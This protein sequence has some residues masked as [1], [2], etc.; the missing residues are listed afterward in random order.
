MAKPNKSTKSK[1]NKEKQEKYDADNEIVIGVTTKRVEEKK[2][3]HTHNKRKKSNTKIIK[4]S[5]NKNTK[6]DYSKE[7]IIK[8][9]NKKRFLLG[10]FVSFL[11][12]TGGIIFLVTT[13]KCYITDIQVE[14]YNRNSEE[15]YIS[16]TKIELNTTN[17]FTITKKNIIQNIKE[18]PYVE[19]VQIKRKLPGTLYITVKERTAE[20]QVLKKEKYIYLDKQ[21]YVLE[22]GD[23]LKNKTKIVGLECNNNEVV[24]GQRLENSD[25]IKLDLILKI[26]NQCEYNNIENEIT[27][28]DISNKI[29]IKLNIDKGNKIVYLGDA[30]NINERILWLKTILDKE[31]KNKGEI[32]IDGDL[33][34][35]RIYFKPTVE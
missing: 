24:E 20:Y 9:S 7:N 29:S 30:S 16:L 23:E 4:K 2:L 13:P 17:I 25:L 18:N 3:T 21:G 28:I 14:G 34:E 22:I 8:R 1:K 35:S 5:N 27:E 19:T 11:I 31:K 10:C 32:F 12:L 33:N 26:I 6:K 15:T